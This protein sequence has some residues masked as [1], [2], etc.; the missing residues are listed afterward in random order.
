M[1]NNV[2]HI[3]Q[4]IWVLYPSKLEQQQVQQHMGVGEGG[5]GRPPPIFMTQVLGAPDTLKKEP[6]STFTEKAI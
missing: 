5:R 6:L 1:S 2:V 3:T 4:G